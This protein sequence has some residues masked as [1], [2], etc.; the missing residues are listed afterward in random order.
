MV[1]G[2]GI[3]GSTS[4]QFS[5]REIAYEDFDNVDKIFIRER[6]KEGRFLKRK[7]ER[8]F[9]NDSIL[10]SKVFMGNIQRSITLPAIKY[11]PLEKEA[12]AIKTN[13]GQ[14]G[15]EIKLFDKENNI[16][17][18][19]WIGRNSNNED[20]TAYL[21]NGADQPYI[22]EIPFSRGTLRGLFLFKEGG[23]RDKNV[24]KY[25]PD[26]IAQIKINYPKNTDS[27][28][29]LDKRSDGGYDIT[30]LYPSGQSEKRKVNQKAIENFLIE[31]KELNSETFEIGNPNEEKVKSS[32]PFMICDITLDDGTSKS[33]KFWPFKD[34]FGND[35]DPELR[36]TLEMVERFFL[37]AGPNEFYLV[38]HRTYKNLMVTYNFFYI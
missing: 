2:D 34:Y 20:G 5:D 4:S 18:D 12:K 7:G 9:Y 8:W 15:I 24:A 21:V 30:P 38:Q 17:R 14:V 31:F 32:V 28:F 26:E 29:I 10:V 22:M 33:Y 23:I 27:S 35:I 16:L 3:G 11:I 36:K 6:N 19:Y 1:K 37:D 25:N 13:M